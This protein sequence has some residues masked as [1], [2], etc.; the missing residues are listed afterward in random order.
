MPTTEST[1]QDR[2]CTLKC[3]TN[4]LDKVESVEIPQGSKEDTISFLLGLF[5]VTDDQSSKQW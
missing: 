5:E 1:V 4:T 2:M 3:I